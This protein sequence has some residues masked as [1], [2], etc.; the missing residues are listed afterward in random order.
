MRIGV[1]FR[2]R[3]RPRRSYTEIAGPEPIRNT[4]TRCP[5]AKCIHHLQI[6]RISKLSNRAE[7]GGKPN[8]AFFLSLIMGKS[9]PRGDEV[10]VDICNDRPLF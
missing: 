3:P 9:N 10:G 6:Y 4:T 2:G 5:T 1:M 7:C 8:L